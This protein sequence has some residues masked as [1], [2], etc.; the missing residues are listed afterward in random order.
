MCPKSSTNSFRICLWSS[1][2]A[3]IVI[4]SR[5]PINFGC[6]LFRL[7]LMARMR[8]M[9]FW[10]VVFVRDQPFFILGGDLEL[11]SVGKGVVNLLPLS[12]FLVRFRYL[13]FFLCF[14]LLF[15]YTVASYCCFSTLILKSSCSDRAFFDFEQFGCYRNRTMIYFAFSLF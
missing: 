3:F 7:T 1:F 15:F 14:L 2:G 9:M 5:S 12:T 10:Y 4:A 13:F 6:L 8:A 11:V